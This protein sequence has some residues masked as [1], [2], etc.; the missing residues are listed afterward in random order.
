MRKLELVQP[1]D[2]VPAYGDETPDP[3]VMRCRA[4][5]HSVRNLS[6]MTEA[7]ALSFLERRRPG[8]CVR[9]QFDAEDHRIVFSDGA[10][11]LAWRLAKGARPI[12]AIASLLAG[13]DSSPKDAQE[14]L[15]TAT[16]LAA[17]TSQIATPPSDA[18]HPSASVG[19]EASSA[20]SPPSAAPSG[21]A[22]VPPSGS[23]PPGSG[24]PGS[25]AAVSGQAT[26]AHSKKPKSLQEMG[27]Y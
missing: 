24:A 16:A 2:F 1:C 27:G 10:G 6:E 13:C 7:D 9:F 22:C 19:L 4:C 21:S 20:S 25:S 17:K 15:A 14:S 3:R 26:A 18:P 5:G 12:I 11:S 23:A 8:E